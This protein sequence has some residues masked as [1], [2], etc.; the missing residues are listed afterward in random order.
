MTLYNISPTLPPFL[1]PSLSLLL[2]FL[3]LHAVSCLRSLRVITSKELRAL[4]RALVTWRRAADASQLTAVRA[5]AESRAAETLRLREQCRISSERLRDV[6]SGS[7]L[8]A[9]LIAEKALNR[10]GYDSLSLFLSLFISLLKKV[11]SLCACIYDMFTGSSHLQTRSFTH[12]S[13]RASIRCC[14]WPVCPAAKGR[15]SSV[16]C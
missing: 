7:D 3:V 4:H 11:C 6:S 2:L 16:T 15:S 5:A 12:R 14:R 9:S 1:S 8:Y 10:S 13:A